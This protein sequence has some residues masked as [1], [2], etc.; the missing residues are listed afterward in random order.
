MEVMGRNISVVDGAGPGVVS[1]MYSSKFSYLCEVI[2][3]SI[4][5]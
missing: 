2:I 4:I 5:K 3:L 1:L